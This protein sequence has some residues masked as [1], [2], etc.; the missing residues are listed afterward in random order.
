MHLANCRRTH[1]TFVGP[2]ATIVL[3]TEETSEIRNREVWEFPSRHCS[4]NAPAPIALATYWFDHEPQIRCSVV[5]LL[6]ISFARHDLCASIKEQGLIFVLHAPFIYQMHRIG[7]G[8]WDRGKGKNP[9]HQAPA[10]WF[11]GELGVVTSHHHPSSLQP[12]LAPV[13]LCTVLVVHP[14]ER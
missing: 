7:R 5:L 6:N 4:C 1:L 14:T 10:E 8:L 12:L 9:L 2:S 11:G 3:A 13:F